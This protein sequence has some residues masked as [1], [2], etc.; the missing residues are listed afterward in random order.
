MNTTTDLH[1]T[2]EV[3]EETGKYICAIGDMSIFLKGEKFANCPITNESTTW[4]H[5]K[6]VH[7][8]GDKVTEE[9]HY[10]DK[11]GEHMDFNQGDEFPNCPKSN[12]PTTW[13]HAGK[14]NA[15]D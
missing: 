14:L 4:R 8:S 10:E 5:E 2:N 1:K 7:N 6:H 9:G 15:E 13:K 3:V 11:D 12:Q